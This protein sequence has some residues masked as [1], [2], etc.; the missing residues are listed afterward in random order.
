MP[1]GEDHEA[2]SGIAEELYINPFLCSLSR[3]RAI[4]PKGE[5]RTGFYFFLLTYAACG[6][7]IYRRDLSRKSE[8]SVGAPR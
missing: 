1:A 8:E 3:F 7:I 6:S 4:F 5:R 2:F